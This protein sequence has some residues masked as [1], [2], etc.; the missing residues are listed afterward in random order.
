VVQEIRKEIKDASRGGYKVDEAKVRKTVYARARADATK[1]QDVT[2]DEGSM[3]AIVDGKPAPLVSRTKITAEQILA[4]GLPDLAVEKLGEEAPAAEDVP[5]S[6]HLNIKTVIDNLLLG[7][8]ERREAQKRLAMVTANMQ[9][10]GVI[11]EHGAQVK[12]EIIG[13]LRGIDGL[14]VYYALMNQ[15]L[16]Y[17]LARELVEFLTEHD[18]IQRV[19]D[20]S[21]NDERRMWIKT[22]LRERRRDEPQVSWEDVEA[23][24]EKEHPREL[25][26]VEK[27]HAAFIAVVPHPEL[28]GGKKRKEIW[29]EIEDEDLAFAD[30]VEKHGLQTEEGNL[31]S[32]L[33]RI[34]KFARML[35]EA[36]TLTE[37]DTLQGKVRRKLSVVDERVLEE[38]G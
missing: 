24:Y 29:K 25:T 6:M 35:F 34:M 22:R 15:D 4:I 1:N 31:F 33:A 36:T 8:R 16:D 3:R 32:Y 20:R 17:A 23:E 37:F 13:K 12:G 5:A 10:L 14:F 18:V 9:A 21:G 7:D 27:L 28:H 2:W 19:L 38:L 26:P 30:Y 11:D